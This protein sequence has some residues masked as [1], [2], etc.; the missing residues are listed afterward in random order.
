VADVKTLVLMG[1]EH[2]DCSWSKKKVT[3]NYKAN[4]ASNGDVVSMEID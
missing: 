3:I 4:S 1:A 2:F